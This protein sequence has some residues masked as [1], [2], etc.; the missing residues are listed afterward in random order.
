MLLPARLSPACSVNFPKPVH[1]QKGHSMD[2]P[3]VLIASLALA[4][5][6]CLPLS[7]ALAH[8]EAVAKHGGVVQLAQDLSFELVSHRRGE[9]ATIYIEDHGKPLATS[10]FSGKLTVLQGAAKSEAPLTPSG[11]N[12]LSAPGLKLGSGAKAVAVLTT[13]QKKTVS[14]RF[15]IH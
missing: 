13:P 10:G 2:T 7:P 3:T 11:D 1:L 9:G 6:A 14:V 4:V 8:G 5:S 15:S 12:R